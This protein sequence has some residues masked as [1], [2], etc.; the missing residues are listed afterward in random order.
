MKRTLN[1]QFALLLLL[2]TSIVG[3]KKKDGEPPISVGYV[4]AHNAALLIPRPVNVLIDNNRV[5]N[6]NFLGYLASITG[7]W[8]GAQSGSRTVAVRDTSSSATTNYASRSITIEPTRAYSVFTYD[9]LTSGGTVRMLVLNTDLS[10]PDIGRTAVRFLHLSPDA[11]A[12]DVA[13]LRVNDA[14]TAY[15][16]S[17][18]IRNVSFVGGSPNEAAL[19]AFST[20]PS[21]RYHIRVRPAGTFTNVVSVGTTFTT[22]QL[23]LQGKKHTIF[24]RGFLNNT[25]PGRSSA[26]ALGATVILH[27]P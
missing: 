24:A 14:A 2:A 20:I 25:G 7:N 18:V 23:L 21:G 9:T 8:A 12:V 22:G 16:D 15:A 11:P 1:K 4:S 6:V 26:T 13:L 19:S 5:N 17:V 3:C 10:L 27:N